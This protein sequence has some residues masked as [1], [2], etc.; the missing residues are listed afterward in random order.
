VF[1]LHGDLAEAVTR[2][3]PR[4]RTNDVLLFDAA[5]EHVLPFNPLACA[6]PERIDQVTSG[7]VSAFR[8]LYDSWGPRLE[9]LL[10][11]AVFA[12]VEHNG[13]LR[14]MLRLLTDEVYRD[15][16]VPRIHDEVVRSFWLNEFSAWNSQYR[17]EAVSSVTNKVMPF[18]TNRH[19]RAITSGD[20]SK[21]LDV[22]HV[23][24]RG[25]ILII[26]LSRGR[27][28]QDNATLLGSLLL[29]SVEQAALSRADIPVSGGA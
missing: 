1:D 5:G 17:T 8:K 24:D 16:A 13:N 26:N 10:R 11:Y 12:T 6:S 20:R 29:T 14:D 3:V 22:R 18:L 21:T 2:V 28:G 7:V 23:M 27:L 9:N 19:L 25:Q 15:Q 4:H